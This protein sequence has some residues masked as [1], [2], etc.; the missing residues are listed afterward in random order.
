MS[1]TQMP[2]SLPKTT[3]MLFLLYFFRIVEFAA[4]GDMKEAIDKF[5]GYEL[6]GRRLRVYEDRPSN[7]SR[8]GSYDRS[9][10]NSGRRSRSRDYSRQ[11]SRSYRRSRSDSRSRQSSLR[12]SR[13]NS[14]DRSRSMSDRSMSRGSRDRSSKHSD[15]RSFVSCYCLIVF[16]ETFTFSQ[17]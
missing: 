11:K 16:L 17:S 3:G 4:Y 15:R 13:D 1:P 14:L 10:S 5:D 8:S 6:Y 7:R 2:I 12:H 9:R